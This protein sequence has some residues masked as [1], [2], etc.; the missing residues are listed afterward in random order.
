MQRLNLTHCWK[1]GARPLFVLSWLVLSWLVLGGA[2]VGREKLEISARQMDGFGR[3]VLTFPDRFDLPPYT[4]NS[5][6]GILS[7]VFEEPV[8]LILPD[9]SGALPQFISISR[10][11]PDRKGIRF[12]LKQEI[13]LNKLEA[14]EQLYLDFLPL[15]WQ[16]LAPGLPTAVVEK[17]AKRSQEAADMAELQRRMEYAR[18]HNP[19][20]TISVGR[21]PTFV[22][23][24]F[25]WSEDTEARYVQEGTSAQLIF[26]WP[27]EL[28]LYNL[29][30]DL[31][32]EILSV[33]D[34]VEGADTILTLNLA[35]GVEPRFYKNSDREFVVDI[36][37]MKP[38]AATI[39]AE[40]LLAAAEEERRQRDLE[41][42]RAEE[43]ALAAKQGQV[44]VPVTE[45][46]ELTPRLTRVGSTVRI[47][48]PFI[49][50][51]PAALFQRGDYLWMVLDTTVV[52]NNPDNK[53][54][55][56]SISDDFSV[57]SAGDTQIVRMHMT[58]RGVASL[59]TQGTDWIV[60]I[61]D[62][63]MS[64]TEPVQLD[65][66]QDDRGRFEIVASVD[67]PVRLH[68][69]R[70]PEVGDILEVVTLFPPAHGIVRRLN[71]VDFTALASVQGLVFSPRREQLNI[72][73][74]SKEV[75]IGS[76][77]G[78]VLSSI[79]GSG[80]RKGDGLLPMREAYLDLNGLVETDPAELSKQRESLLSRAATGLGREKVNARLELAHLLL[81]NQLG[82]EAVG[83]LN[84][85][86]GENR[87][88]DLMDDA[89]VTRAA[90]DVVAFRP[91][92]ALETLKQ[93]T[94]A[95]SPDSLMWQAIARTDLGDFK[96]ARL[97]VL[98]SEAVYGS[99][100]NWVQARYLLSAVRAAVETGDREMARR[101]MREMDKVGLT[102]EQFSLKLL[103]EGRIDELGQRFDEAL[104]TYGQVI[105][106]DI[107]PTRAE[108][109]YRTVYLLDRMGR[110]DAEQAIQTLSRESIVW[111]GG[112]VEAKMLQLLARLQF[113]NRKYRDGFSTVREAAEAQVEDDAI[114]AL[115]ERAQEVFADLYLN[116]EA[117]ALD[118]VEA[119]TLF[120]DF[121]YLTP[122]GARGDEMIRNLARRLI[123]VDLLAQA[124][125][126]L[127][128]QVDVRLDGA[129]RSQIAAD[130]AVVYIANHE[131]A[132][133]LK[134]LSRTALAN[135]PPSLERQR[136]LLE[137]RALIDEG[138][139]EI[140]LDVLDRLE[141]RDVDLL[142]V[143]AYWKSQQYRKAAEQIELIYSRRNPDAD[144]AQPARL[145]LVKAAVGYVLDGDELG[146]SRLRSKF[147]QRL[148]NSPEWDLFDYITGDV[149]QSSG[150][151]RSVVA[152]VTNI[153]GLTTFLNAYRQTYGGDGAL[154]PS[155]GKAVS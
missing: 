35:E 26:S 150:D 121:R 1:I 68:E 16:G 64:P 116:G 122:P 113:D 119:L 54:I 67:R 128:Y 75:V 111:R 46:K 80:N 107:R 152:K 34:R 105:S 73:L 9:V 25:D 137:A 20:A 132:K 72:S 110:L 48:L 98:S 10:I 51:T 138:R 61:G 102:T 19:S 143:D 92:D 154:T 97:D 117:D 30:S 130:L 129:A 74:H 36:D 120:Y 60:S 104:D 15:S 108:A 84:L 127:E 2:A 103:L 43:A 133:A 94:F 23:L 27:A 66:R 141:G 41:K 114:L 45:Q 85:L 148:A 58:S 131:P 76:P 21:H 14:G 100:P 89:L 147:A 78:L 81:A 140:A 37:R 7:I 149:V 115:T 93:G 126:L 136:R 39:N 99:Y 155:A 62:D 101:M 47:T 87:V 142:R 79:A 24:L 52:I 49:T 50:E 151:F 90:A 153:D 71:Y 112:P 124:A 123:R 69:I 11:D 8:D 29:I 125:S 57:I 53:D 95:G 38:D 82:Y 65:R 91:A 144:L 6:N 31:P 63:L 4:V 77:E 145:N 33:N 109:I 56:A 17:L 40:A 86:I 70:D 32:E 42:A 3:I 13:R 18:T 88:S 55:L 12:G 83:V 146:L 59:G 28:D 118:P 106:Q 96:G 135:L 139:M 134:V 22:R 5:E 44:G